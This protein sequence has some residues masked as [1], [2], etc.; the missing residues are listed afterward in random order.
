[1]IR[2]IAVCLALA[3]SQPAVRAVGQRS[4][5]VLLDVGPT[6]ERPLARGEEHR[7][8]ISLTSGECARVV[9]DGRGIGLIVRLRGTD[10]R[11]LAD[12]DDEIASRGEEQAEIVAR[13]SGTYT[14]AISARPD[15]TA[16]GSYAIRVVER[17][18][19]TAADRALFE[20]RQLSTSAVRLEKDGRYD[21][22]ASQ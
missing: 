9:V 4:P 12:T 10:D 18:A 7:Y 21:V 8:Q 3:V 6:I 22:A 17:R 11:A 19:A 15:N 13:A 14:I 20:A 1:M 5:E 16:P 2:T